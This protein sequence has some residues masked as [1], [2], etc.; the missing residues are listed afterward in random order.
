MGAD[1]NGWDI[2]LGGV[3]TSAGG[4]SYDNFLVSRESKD[5]HVTLG[6]E[7]LDLADYANFSRGLH[8]V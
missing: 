4:N 7:V 1:K 8:R 5:V 3:P 2:Q 6:V